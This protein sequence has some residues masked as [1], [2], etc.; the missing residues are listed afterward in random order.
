MTKRGIISGILLVASL[1]AACVYGF[2][3]MQR[4]KYPVDSSVLFGVVPPDALVVQRFHS[5][6]TLCETYVSPAALLSRFCVSDNGLSHFLHEVY[7]AK[8]ETSV[9]SKLF[10]AEALFSL[11]QTGKNNL[12]LLLGVKYAQDPSVFAALCDE[13]G[14]ATLYKPYN[15]VDIYQLSQGSTLFYLA[16]T[17]GFLL[18]ATSPVVVE[19][20]IRHLANGRSLI[21]NQAFASLVTLS[22]T[23]SESN[24]YLNVQ[25]VDKLFGS[26]LGRRM[27][28][29]ADFFCNSASWIAL[30]GSVSVDLIHLNGYLLVDKG[31]A[32]YL[33]TFS[34]QVPAAVKI[35]ESVPPTTLAFI[36]FSLSDFPGYLNQYNNYLEI[37]KKSK[38]AVA[39]VKEW[40]TKTQLNL[41]EWFESL[42]PAEVALAW[43]PV[44]E[45]YQ[46]VTLVRSHQIQ[47]LRKQL[48]FPSS[49]NK[50][51]P[52]VLPNPADGAIALT[53]GSFFT[54]S[55]ESH[56]TILN[57]TLIFGS[58]EALASLAQG[59]DKGSSLYSVM[60][61]GRIKGKW[62]EDAG[63]TCVWQASGARDSLY[64]LCDPRH[65]PLIKEALAPYPNTWTIFQISYLGSRP[66]ANLLF[67]VDDALRQPNQSSRAPSKEALDGESIPMA[68]GS[69]PIFNHASR[70]HEE[71]EQMPDSTL[72]LKD[73]YGKQVWRTRR[74]YAIV[75]RVAQM[76]YFKN[77]KLQML[78]VS[79]GT[80]LCL[81]DILG[82]LTA[83]YPI[84]MAIPVRKGPFLFDHKS[85]KE[86][87]MFLIHTDNSLRLYDRSGVAVADWKPFIPE[88]RIEQEP[89]KLSY[90]GGYY[91]I[92]YGAQRDYFLKPDGTIAVVLQRRDRLK[93][94]ADI[95]IDA[96]GMLTGTTAEGRILTVQL[97]TG[98]IKTH[99]P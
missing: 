9:F 98:T 47:Q 3:S 56:Y 58:Q 68:I 95:N 5:F 33:S 31:D 84:K 63:F 45:G 53:M 51:P 71:I 69:F 66:Y 10:R 39:Q 99:K 38:Q 54:K 76:D 89:V 16:V 12:Q 81:L 32:N 30:E 94:D 11:H 4:H 93:P 88:D 65:I 34:Q 14:G 43:V 41:S 17:E 25:Q 2:L 44:N 20:S 78:F 35:W 86:Y 82:R 55:A 6:E 22:S 52:T 21:D 97:S 59:Y 50:Q 57:N 75:D 49:D 74:K 40:E 85:N 83:P 37:H 62:M 61:Q 79:G 42:Y 67:G 60:R 28:R 70:K 13:L 24:V 36:S 92:V 72:V 7:H 15:K 19:S 8:S 87:E 77:D 29:Y 18:A 91:W 90:D 73:M 23:T 27:Q 80:E 48:D 1:L 46:W 96:N 64:H 26:L